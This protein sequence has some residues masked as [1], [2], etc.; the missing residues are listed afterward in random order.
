MK[1]ILLTLFILLQVTIHA[2]HT[3]QEFFKKDYSQK[4]SKSI[5]TNDED[6]IIGLHDIYD[7]GIE[8]IKVSKNGK[9][10]WSKSLSEGN[11]YIKILSLIPTSK[12]GF[13]AALTS[14]DSVNGIKYILYY[15]DS[16]GNALWQKEF[17]PM[18]APYDI[19]E[20]ILV[21]A[22][23]GG[24]YF[25]QKNKKNTQYAAIAEKDEVLKFDVSGKVVWRNFF[26]IMNEADTY[27]AAVIGAT[28]TADGGIAMAVAAET[29]GNWYKLH[30]VKCSS[31]GRPEW[32]Y[33]LD[34]LIFSE[35]GLVQLM[36]I[37]E[38][39]NIVFVL[40]SNT[41]GSKYT[42]CI[43]NER[44]GKVKTFN[45]PRD[46]FHL[47]YFLK[48]NSLNLVKG[49]MFKIIDFQNSQQFSFDNMY[50]F[51]KDW[52]LMNVTTAQR[53]P[54]VPNILLEKYDKFGRICTDNSGRTFDSTVTKGELSLFKS[55]FHL[56][57]TLTKE[58]KEASLSV[59]ESKNY[60]KKLCIAEVYAKQ[61]SDTLISTI[62]L[63]GSLIDVKLASTFVKN[64]LTLSI[65]NDKIQKAGMQ[66]FNGAGSIMLKRDFNTQ[67]G[68]SILNQDVSIFPSGIYYIRI[69]GNNSSKYL[70]FLKN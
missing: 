61:V 54:F 57:D 14:R 62:Q 36:T 28:E 10:V 4:A 35:R 38:T 26:N 42:Y 31:N 16:L 18:D 41:N 30:F 44:T 69:V 50:C 12:N 33:N 64:Y 49:K 48:K 1:P 23:D 32:R 59:F 2:Q 8:F 22:K 68:V 27:G 15:S 20:A 53:E 13:V 37:D 19:S 43:L 3:F 51:T 65:T 52:S 21:N 70:K 58:I 6:V 39:E 63:S 47:Q 29:T 56:I 7:Q 40:E 60:L 11:N 55:S 67:N 46:V 5:I 66:I 17:E 25:I 45:F 24:L 34:S 9:Y